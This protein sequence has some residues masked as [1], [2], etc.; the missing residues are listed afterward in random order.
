MQSQIWNPSFLQFVVLDY[1][2]FDANHLF[3]V[4]QSFGDIFMLFQAGQILNW[5]ILCFGQL[6][7]IRMLTYLKERQKISLKKLRKNLFK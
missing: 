6:G 3:E 2:F 1:I 4:A 7:T 5:Y